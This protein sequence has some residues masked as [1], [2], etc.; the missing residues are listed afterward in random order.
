MA[1]RLLVPGPANDADADAV[2]ADEAA[3]L[4]TAVPAEDRSSP[5]LAANLVEAI[6][7]AL[8]RRED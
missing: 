4:R 1:T 2:F 3:A 8:A 7:G 5:H 6:G